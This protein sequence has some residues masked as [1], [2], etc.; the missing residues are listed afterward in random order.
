MKQRK[1]PKKY[2]LCF[3]DPN[4]PGALKYYT[5]ASDYDD[6]HQGYGYH[7]SDDIND[8]LPK[9]K[10]YLQRQMNNLFR[11]GKY[12]E[13]FG[14]WGMNKLPSYFSIREIEIKYILV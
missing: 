1:K 4:N 6:K 3:H 13:V 9:S 5:G 2:V 10:H 11:N 14:Y 8:A 12:A 7:F